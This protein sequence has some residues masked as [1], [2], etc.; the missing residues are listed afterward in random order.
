MQYAGGTVLKL[1]K[2]FNKQ[3]T[4]F[5]LSDKHGFC[6]LLFSLDISMKLIAKVR[7]T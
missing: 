2:K 6:R 5:K 4:D 7:L 1:N 3:R